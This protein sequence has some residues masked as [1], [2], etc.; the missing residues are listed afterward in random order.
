MAP[1]LRNVTLHTGPFSRLDHQ[2]LECRRGGWLVR[3]QDWHRARRCKTDRARGAHRDPCLRGVERA[4]V[5][6]AEEA[7]ARQLSIGQVEDGEA[8]WREQARVVFLTVVSGGLRRGEILG[9]RWREVSLADPAGATLRVRETWVRNA[10]DIPKSEK[11]E[12]TIALGERLA[13]E[14]FDHRARTPYQ[15][16]DERVFCSATGRP[17]DPVRYAATF[18]LALKRAKVDKPMRPF[19][20]GRHTSITNAAAA[21]VAPAALGAGWT[22][23]L[24][25]DAGLHRPGRRDVP[26]GGRAPRGEVAR[27]EV[28]AEA[29]SCLA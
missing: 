13:S 14:L 1:F 3:C 19:H 11:S 8:A 27:A 9:L 17:L 5:E 12:R 24:Q 18:R 25:D 6:L 15:G 20:D 22:L 4:F 23:R 7:R 10:P 16:D 26:P 21:G 28:R 2:T 29:C